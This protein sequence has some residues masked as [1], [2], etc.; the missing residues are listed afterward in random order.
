MFGLQM[1]DIAI[2][3]IFI[4]LL[5]ALICTA[6]NELIA[7]LLDRR[8]KNLETGISNLLFEKGVTIEDQRDGIKKDLAKL[9]YNHPLIKAM[10]E[11]GTNPSYIPSRTFALVLTDIIAP[12]G[13]DVARGIEDI[14]KAIKGLSEKSDI[15]R[16]LLL[17]VQEAG[18]NLEK[19]HDQLEVWFNNAMERVSAWYKRKTQFWVVALA[20]IITAISNADTIQIAKSITNDPALRNA[21]VAQAQELAKN[22]PSKIAIKQSPQGKVET[23]NL[24]AESNDSS[25]KKSNEEIIKENI[26]K[27]Q[28][29]GMKLGWKEIPK[30]GYDFSTA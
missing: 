8:T 18:D 28:D 11:N 22:P 20:I 2:G 15:K 30:D 7:G 6:A 17:L 14:R 1:L 3:L 13:L 25:D 23:S 26:E 27:L 10:R 24:S 4:Y 21:L 9:F 16:I 5:L 19:W 29:L 12:A